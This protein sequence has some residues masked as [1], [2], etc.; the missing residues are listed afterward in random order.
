MDGGQDGLQD[1]RAL[2]DTVAQVLKQNG[3]V[4]FEIGKG[5]EDDVTAIMQAKK[6]RFQKSYRDLGN[7]TRVLV[8]FNMI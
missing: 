3:L 7:I 8:F 1:Y 2:S 6:L 5:Q 4:F